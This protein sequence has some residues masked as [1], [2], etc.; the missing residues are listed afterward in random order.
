MLTDVGIPYDEMARWATVFNLKQM[1][2]TLL[3]LRDNE[4]DSIDQL[5]KI[6]EE[7]TAKKDQL[8]EIVKS[9]EKHLSEIADLRKHI[10]DYVG[11]KKVYVAYRKAGYNESFLEQHR[12]EIMRHKKAKQSGFRM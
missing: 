10:V 11:T 4:I 6:A 3:F 1:A 12:E 5:S 8:L 9:H 7:Q 2:K